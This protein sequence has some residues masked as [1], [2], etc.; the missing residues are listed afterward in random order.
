MRFHLALWAAKLSSR[1][2]RLIAKDRGTNLPGELALKIDPQFVSHIKGVDPSKAVFITGTNGKSTST[3]LVYHI[4]TQSGFKVCSNLA[5]A[6]LLTGVAAAMAADCTLG[7]RFRADAIVMETD[8]RFLQFIRA[9][10]PAKYVCVTNIQKDQAQRNGEPSFV[11]GKIRQALDEDTVLILNQNEPNALSLADQVKRVITYGVRENS[12]SFDKEDD[13][14]AVSMPCPRCHNPVRFGKY[15]IENVGPFRCPVCG[16]GEGEPDYLVEDVDFDGKRFTVDGTEYAFNSNTAY[17]L[18][19]YI[20]GLA[21]ASDMGVPREK[22][23]AALAGFTENRGLVE[24]RMVGEKKLDFIKMKQENSETLQSSLNL[25]AEDR[26]KKNLLIYHTEYID[27]F[28]P[29]ANAFYL[30]DCDFRGLLRSGIGHWACMSESLCRSMA[31]RLLYDGFP[32]KT[33]SVLPD[34]K[35]ETIRSV[36]DYADAEKSYLIA[37]LT[38]WKTWGG[39]DL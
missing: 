17:F 33:M 13:F 9:Q 38:F 6:N 15:N 2:I 29:Y 19:C 8:E 25:A 21:V 32:E 20:L 34:S 16:F 26:D 37:E 10:L 35:E 27:L 12:R 18:Y 7:G 36:L 4:L 1:L 22:L 23:Q 3:N 11:L 24:Y 5:G 30:F 28:P 14:F 39:G 31:I